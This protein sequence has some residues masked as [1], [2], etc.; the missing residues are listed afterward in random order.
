M[1]PPTS[2]L[3]PLRLR[4]SRQGGF[5]LVEALVATFILAQ[6]CMGLLSV[7]VQSR[8][9][10]EGSIRQ[11]ATLALFQGHLEQLRNID[12][13]RLTVSPA[14]PPDTPVTIPTA[15]DGGGSV[16]LTLSVGTPPATVPAVGTTPPGAVDNLR[17][18]DLNH[19]PDNPAD[20]V[21]VNV[22]VWI[23]DLASG[24]ATA[25]PAKSILMIYTWEAR[26]GKNV[27]TFRKSIGTIRSSVPSY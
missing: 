10:T 1:Q 8:Q 27:R 7:L 13:S 20:D 15:L 16:P 6:F 9:L 25:T 23:T 3:P 18:V 4:R 19:T 22:W 21:S 24:D 26:D 14:D 11:G 17:V 12:Y 5:T 2:L